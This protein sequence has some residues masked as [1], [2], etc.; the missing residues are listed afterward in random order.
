MTD[1]K[2]YKISKEK[3]EEMI[4]RVK[5]FFSKKEA[6]KSA[7]WPLGSFLIL[8]LKN[9]QMNFTIKGCSIHINI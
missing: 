1:D 7:I 3:R 8:L 9:Y 6:K 2:K 5:A 4:G